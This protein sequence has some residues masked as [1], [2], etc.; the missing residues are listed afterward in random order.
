MSEARELRGYLF[1]NSAMSDAQRAVQAAH[2]AVEIYH[3]NKT[4]A[5]CAEW[6]ESHKTLILLDGGYHGAMLNNYAELTRMCKKLSLPYAAFFEDFETMNHLFT[7]FGAIIP[8]H[9]YDMDIPPEY[10]DPEYPLW[11]DQQ[12]AVF[13]RNFRLLK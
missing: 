2:A 7:G 11:Y 10:L 4:D 9:I 5:L 6:A 12:L 8:N 3:K 13:L 1:I